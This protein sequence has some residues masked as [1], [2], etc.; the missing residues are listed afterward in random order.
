MTVDL[1]IKHYGFLGI[2][3]TTNSF[4]QTYQNFA[5]YSR[6]PRAAAKQANAKATDLVEDHTWVLL[7][8]VGVLVAVNVVIVIG[9]LR[10]RKQK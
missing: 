7:L 9:I 6:L 3:S 1:K 4:V 8:V 5:P 10:K 2:G